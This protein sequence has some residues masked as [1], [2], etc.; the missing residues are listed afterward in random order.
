VLL[1]VCK[2]SGD[3]TCFAMKEIL[4][5]NPNLGK[6]TS[7]RNNSSGN[8]IQETKFLKEQVH[9]LYNIFKICFGRMNFEVISRV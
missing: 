6:T 7:E 5:T 9:I 2:K 4:L 3:G 8:I 1:Q